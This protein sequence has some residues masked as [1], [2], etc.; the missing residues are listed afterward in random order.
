MD[1]LSTWP[2][3]SGDISIVNPAYSC[4]SSVGGNK[5]CCQASNCMKLKAEAYIQRVFTVDYGSSYCLTFNL[6]SGSNAFECEETFSILYTCGSSST[7]SSV[8]VTYYGNEVDAGRVSIS[9]PCSWR[10]QI[11]LM[12]VSTASFE[13]VYI[14]E[15]RISANANNC[16]SVKG[17]STLI[18]TPV[19]NGEYAGYDDMSCLSSHVGW[20]YPAS[21]GV[22][23]NSTRCVS[24]KCI[25]LSNGYLEKTFGSA[26][27]YPG[28]YCL[29]FHAYF[30]DFKSNGSLWIG[31]GCD[32]GYAW[33]GLDT[34]Y[35]GSSNY[36]DW[37]FYS[38]PCSGYNPIAIRFYIEYDLVYID[39]VSIT[40][41]AECSVAVTDTNDDTTESNNLNW[42]S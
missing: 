37:Y 26:Q 28:P 31:Y 15:V 23:T 29:R 34:V 21:A 9:I 30:D 24:S 2:S 16:P 32:W 22:A 6:I 35:P 25:Y 17:V 10:T 42:L 20:Y 12:F 3:R 18:G 39:E 19:N 36:G 8:L 7:V 33:M 5:A 4:G 38:L 1:S 40:S 13:E 11:T 14:D 27:L 41:G